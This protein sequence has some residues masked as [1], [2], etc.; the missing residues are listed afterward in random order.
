MIEKTYNVS[1]MTCQ[2]CVKAVEMEL[3]ELGLDSF[4]V[5]LGVVKAKFDKNIISENKII[6]AIKEAGYEVVE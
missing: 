4:K 6:N 5:E 2:H 1:G 3:K